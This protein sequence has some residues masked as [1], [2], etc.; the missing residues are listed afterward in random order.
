[1]SDRT[2]KILATVTAVA[3]GIGGLVFLMSESLS[4]TVSYYKHVD[5]VMAAPQDWAGKKMQVHG[6]VEAGSINA[7]IEGQ[8]SIRDFIL[9]AKGKR[10]RV[11]HKGPAP[12]TFKDLAEVV[13]TGDLV[14]NESG[15]WELHA[16]EL[17]AKCPSKYEEGRRTKELAAPR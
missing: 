2:A 7:R 16:D 14:Q 11:F 1:M 13:A 15:E 17:S 5:E 9:E 4:D 10:I 12:D 3:L 6:H 8:E